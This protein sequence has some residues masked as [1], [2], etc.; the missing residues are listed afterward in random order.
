[1]FRIKLKTVSCC[2]SSAPPLLLLCSSSTLLALT[3]RAGPPLPPSSSGSG[4][5]RW[6]RGKWSGDGPG[7]QS[8]VRQAPLLPSDSCTV[9]PA[10]PP[11]AGLRQ[12]ARAGGGEAVEASVEACEPR[13]LSQPRRQLPSP[14]LRH[15]K[16]VV[17]QVQVSQRSTL[18]Q[19]PPQH[20]HAVIT[21]AVVAQVQMSQR[22]A[23][24]QHPHHT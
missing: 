7:V 8:V 12:H 19:R 2:S 22:R 6:G 11:L 15:P 24:S 4:G 13:A 16:V 14:L 18:P 17:A 20:P 3:A 5:E 9:P 21:D 1:M 23:L 10:P